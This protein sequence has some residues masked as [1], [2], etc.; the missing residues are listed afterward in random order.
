MDT[1]FAEDLAHLSRREFI[2]K[3]GAG[4]LG[5]FGLPFLGRYERVER[6]NPARDKS[7]ILV[8]RGTDDSVPVFDKPS[9]SG[10]LKRMYYRDVIFK[11]DEVPEMNRGQGVYLQRYKDGGLVDATTFTWKAGLKDENNKLFEPSELKDWKGERAQAGRIV[12]RGWSRGG[13]FG[14][15]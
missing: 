6:L 13:K 12:P 4:L 2:R 15:N 10:T 3:S 14:E 8:G 5:L 7:A 9:F 11:I 1:L